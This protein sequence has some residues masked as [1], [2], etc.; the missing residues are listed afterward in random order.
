VKRERWA[1][2][3]GLVLALAGNAIGLG[4]FLRFPGQAAANGGGAFMIPYFLSLLL[5]GIPLMWAEC[6][7]GRF[8]GRHGHGH[9]GGMFDTL[10][11]HPLSKYVGVFGI[12]I[13]F[14]VALYYIPITSWCLAFSWFSLTGAYEGLETRAELGAFL[15]AFQGWEANEH[16]AGRGPLYL[17]FGITLG[18]TLLT[19]ARGVAL[20]I[21]RLAKLA[22]PALFGMA[23]LLAVRVLTLEPPEGAGPDQTVLSGLGFVWNPDLTALANPAVWLAAAGQ[24]FFT[25]SVG[26]G[27]IHTYMSYVGPDEDVALTGLSMASLNEFAEVVLGGT[28]AITASVVFFGIAAT[29]DIAR[30][31]FDLGFQ[32]M[33]VIFLQLPFGRVLGALWFLLLF[34]AGLTSAVAIT[35]PTVALIQEGFSVTRERAVALV[36]AALALLSVPPLWFAGVLDDLDFWAGSFAL[37]VFGLAEV[38]IFAWGFGIERGWTEITRGAAIRVPR[39]LVPIL[40]YVTPLF[41]AVILLAFSIQNLP[42]VLLSGGLEI[43]LGRILMLAIFAALTLLVRRALKSRPGREADA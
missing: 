9:T 30:S 21:E 4:N 38:L 31:T 12:F 42:D 10:W 18:V 13:P 1:T 19:L 36:G 24:V 11:A 28:I 8:G 32:S 41:L 23:V 33:A 34:F 37:L 17:F 22:L 40:K 35:Q 39:I 25:L 16:F 43:W 15:A 27:I 7:I 6:A 29:G 20:G 26:W 14:T 3:L 5:I 2:R